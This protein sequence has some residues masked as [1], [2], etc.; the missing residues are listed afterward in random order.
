VSVFYVAFH[1]VPVKVHW[2]LFFLSLDT[3][4]SLCTFLLGPTIIF[5]LIRYPFRSLFHNL[6]FGFRHDILRIGI[7]RRMMGCEGCLLQWRIFF[8]GIGRVVVWG[9]RIHDVGGLGV[10]SRYEI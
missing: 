7:H 5:L 3:A 2:D 8:L 4:T 9:S 6:F 1:P 10:Y